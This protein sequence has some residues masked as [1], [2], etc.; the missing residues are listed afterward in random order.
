MFLACQILELHISV[1][2]QKQNNNKK[3]NSGQ[4]HVSFAIMVIELLMRHDQLHQIK[5]D[6][7][8]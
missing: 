4:I 3:K 8:R 2:Q 1:A 7:F 6:S 5:P